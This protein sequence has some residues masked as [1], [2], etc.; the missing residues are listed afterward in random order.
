MPRLSVVGG[1]RV[2]RTLA[3]LWATAGCFEIA[4]VV[5]THTA[6]A[7]QAVRFIGQGRPRAGLDGLQPADLWL[8]S[9]PDDRLAQVADELATYTTVREGDVAC[10][11]SGALGAAVLGPLGA[12]GA[13][14]ASLHPMHSFADPSVSLTA[15]AGTWCALEGVPQA[16]QRLRPA[17]ERIGGRCVE[18][19]SDA[20][21]LYHAG[22]VLAANY[23]VALLDQAAALVSAA[24]IPRDDALALLEPLVRGTVDNLFRD[25]SSAALT[26]PVARGDA[27]LVA[28]QMAA[29]AAHDATAGAIYRELGNAAL[30]I[31]SRQGKLTDEQ[32]AALADALAAAK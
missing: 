27:A 10:H 29:V 31:A 26:G 12:H 9:V 11:C 18:I 2:G 28:T 21:L 6:N 25:G 19:A 5:C 15:F 32:L 7:E 8:I 17:V 4:D 13:A 22:G 20:K 23:L 14:L 24:G 1:G 30:A 16:L 3:R